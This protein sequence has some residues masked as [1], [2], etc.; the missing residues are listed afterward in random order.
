M[1]AKAGGQEV[2]NQPKQPGE[3]LSQKF[4]TRPTNAAHS[5]GSTQC[6]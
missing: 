6:L 3:I 1:K 2:Q 5:Q 4:L